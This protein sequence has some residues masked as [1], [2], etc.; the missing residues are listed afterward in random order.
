MSPYLA[1]KTVHILSSTLIFGTGLGSVYYL[2]G[3][4]R[5]RNLEAL[6]LTTRLVVWADWIFTTPAIVIQPVTGAW[7]ML[8]LGYRFDSAWFAWVAVLYLVAGACWIP[9]VVV[10]YRLRGHAAAAAAW[11][12]LPRDYYRLMRWWIALGVG[13]FAAVLALFAL[14]V[15]RPGL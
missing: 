2:W 15:F 14:M 4:H 10:Q 3:A 1:L 11:E 7:L 8:V 9:V 12:A 5:S 6:R 13:A